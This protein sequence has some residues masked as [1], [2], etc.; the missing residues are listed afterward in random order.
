MTKEHYFENPDTKVKENFPVLVA[1]AHEHIDG[2]LP[3]VQRA[4]KHATAEEKPS[5]DVELMQ[6]LE[7]IHAHVMQLDNRDKILNSCIAELQQATA[8]LKTQVADRQKTEALED[9]SKTFK[10]DKKTGLFT[11]IIGVITFL[12]GLLL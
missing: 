12:G 3:C 10:L 8:D 6:A 7:L 1:I 5:T 11:G 9:L 4:V 2:C